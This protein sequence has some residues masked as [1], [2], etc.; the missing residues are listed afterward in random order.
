[1]TQPIINVVWYKRDLR[2]QDHAPLVAAADEGAVVP[3]YIVEPEVL[4]APDMDAMHYAFIAEC[5]AELR[6]DLTALGAPLIV[7]VGDPVEVFNAMHQQQPL[8]RIL[9]H[10]ETGNALTFA[11]DLRVADWARAHGVGFDEWPNNGVVR[12]LGTRDGWSSIWNRRINAPLIDAPS[13]LRATSI[14]PGRIPDVAELSL[15]A[16]HPA[17]ATRRQS[18]SGGESAAHET[19][20]SFL[21][22]RGHAYQREISAPAKA[23]RSCSRLSPYLAYGALSIRQVVDAALTSDLPKRASSAFVSRLHWHCH[24][25]QKL[26]SQ[27]SIETQCFNPLYESLRGEPDAARLSAWQ[28]GKTG[29]PFVDACIRA[30]QTQGWINFRMRA[31]LTSF[32]AYDLWLDWRSFRDFLARQFVDYEPGI[33]ISQLQMQSGVTGIN[34]PRMYNPIKQGYDH[35]PQGDFIRCWVPELRSV[36]TLFIHEPW[37]MSPLEIAESGV[38]LGEIYPLPV[39]DHTEAIRAARAAI[40]DVRRSSE[41]HAAAASVFDQHGSRRGRRDRV[42]Q[43]QY[44]ARR[45]SGQDAERF[46]SPSVADKQLSLFE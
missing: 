1:M 35:D 28:S 31:M 27:P 37:K 26:E 20:R 33:H 40:G 21:D 10:E 2:V 6:D 42:S 46:D 22:E 39:V 4:G 30:L 45:S 36:P 14:A 11:R 9:A 5:L 34:T 12:R 23:L 3:L 38:R 43:R 15:K 41:H 8:A 29:Y 16:L 13:A 32:A 19:L 44:R 18:Q 7:R 24:F 17:V 25:I